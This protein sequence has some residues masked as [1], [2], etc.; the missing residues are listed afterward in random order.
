MRHVGRL[1]VWLCMLTGCGSIQRPQN[2]NPVMH[3]PPRRMS[4]DDSS[5]KAS[6]LADSSQTSDIRQ[7]AL[8]SADQLDDAKVFNATVVARVN[9]APVFAGEVLERWGPVLKTAQARLSPEDFAELRKAIVQL[10]LRGNIERKLLAER[11]RS[12]L[13]PEQ[14]KQLEAHVDR[15]FEKEIEKLKQQLEVSTRTELELALNERGTTLEAYK[16]G[17]VTQRLAIEYVGSHIERP[18]PLTRPELVAYYQ[19]HLDEYKIPARVLWQQVQVSWNPRF[20]R[21]EAARKIEQARQ[22]LLR[23]E[24][25]EDVARQFSD[26]PTASE[27]GRWDWTN[28]GS[29]AEQKLEDTLFQLPVGT[30]SP[31][32]EGRSAFHLVKVLDRQ[33]ESRRPFAELQDE[34]AEKLEAERRHNLPEQFV[35]RLYQEAI[36]ETS[37]DLSPEGL[38]AASA[39]MSQFFQQAGIN[40]SRG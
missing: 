19:A 18:P 2:V 4:L 3:A 14:I 30:V 21:E 38:Q 11:M 20:S 34:I 6:S 35:E 7:A 29:L 9:G 5:H 25:F 32:I 16:E 37:Y 28:R 13:K 12:S 15:L 27:G 10:N 39:K 31:V 23:G 33:A 22:A 36:I 17:F 24:S 40:L 8:R 26:G 1:A